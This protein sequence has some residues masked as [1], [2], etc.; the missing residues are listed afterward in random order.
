M[1]AAVHPPG[2]PP[3]PA[4]H[5]GPRFGARVPL[6]RRRQQQGR[7]P[8][9]GQPGAAQPAGAAT[10]RPLPCCFAAVLSLS[11]NL[12]GSSLHPSCA[13]LG[14]VCQQEAL[15]ALRSHGWRTSNCTRTIGAA[16]GCG[17][18]QEPAAAPS[19]VWH[20]RKHTPK[21]M[22]RSASESGCGWAEQ[23]LTRCC[24]CCC[25][26]Q[27]AQGGVDGAAHGVH[28]LARP[29][30]GGAAGGP[31]SGAPLHPQHP[32]GR[33]PVCCL[34][35]WVGGT[36]ALLAQQMSLCTIGHMDPGHASCTANAADTPV[37]L[38]LLAPRLHARLIWQTTPC[39][40]VRVQGAAMLLGPTCHCGEAWSR[41]HP[42]SAHG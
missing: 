22:Q 29:A 35:G 31:S 25:T 10:A 13:P 16:A 21:A 19:I 34:A 33:W 39:W 6:R 14:S 28:Q 40:S 7:L 11:Q 26:D 23:P 9:R 37:L 36:V 8:A 4:A 17:W 27:G 18:C 30:Q 41:T 1:C 32:A 2:G 42:T 5:A 12:D 38:P 3:H 24:C 15:L 20:V